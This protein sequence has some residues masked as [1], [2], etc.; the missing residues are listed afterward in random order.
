MISQ[1]IVDLLNEKYEKYNHVNFIETD[2]IFIPHQFTKKQDIEIAGFFTATLAW[3]QR[4]TIIS[5]SM[6]LMQ[7]MDMS[8]YNFVMNAKNGDLKKLKDFK[9]RTFNLTDTLYFIEFFKN[10]YSNSSSLETAFLKS[11]GLLKDKLIA[12]QKYFFLLPEY[13]ER[14]KKHVS[15]PLKNSACKRINMFLRWM[16]RKD[17]KGVDFGIWNQISTKDLI[18]PCDVHV[19]RTAQILNLTTLE[20]PGW[21]MAEEITSNL[22]RIDDQDPVKY[23]FALFGLGIEKYFDNFR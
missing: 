9:H 16:V 11:D 12:F 21:K 15:S 6:E 4:K 14:T 13:P 3:G 20:K 10:H 8:P 5:K 19:E 23:D 2:P 22:I 7:I 1:K 17:S 18:I